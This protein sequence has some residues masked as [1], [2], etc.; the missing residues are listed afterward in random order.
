VQSLLLNPGDNDNKHK[1]TGLR[2]DCYIAQMTPSTV[3]LVELVFPDNHK[4]SVEKK[5]CDAK[6]QITGQLLQD[7][8]VRITERR[9]AVAWRTLAIITR[10]LR[11]P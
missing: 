8:I 7:C 6:L 5:L 10:R 3:S 9:C 11:C 2:D 1:L 4:K